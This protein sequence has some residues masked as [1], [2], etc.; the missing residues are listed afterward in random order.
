MAT[1][2]LW[3]SRALVRDARTGRSWVSVGRSRG[4]RA[5]GVLFGGRWERGRAEHH[6]RG[7]GCGERQ[8]EECTSNTIQSAN[9]EADSRHAVVHGRCGITAPVA[10]VA[11]S[12]Q[13]CHDHV[14]S[15]LWS[16][17]S[18]GFGGVPPRCCSCSRDK[19]LSPN[20]ARSREGSQFPHRRNP[21][22]LPA[23]SNS[24]EPF[25]IRY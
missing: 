17:G 2:E 20:R 22:Q 18:V 14:Q 4:G 8:P 19:C 5:G 7:C 21:S 9:I 6:L 23:M 12:C 24:N 3:S 16:R 1:P 10:A 15:V 13:E 25:Y 11:V